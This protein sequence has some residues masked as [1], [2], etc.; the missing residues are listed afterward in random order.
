MNNVI[1]R[2]VRTFGFWDPFFNEMNVSPRS[3]MVNR[4]SSK[5]SIPAVNIQEMDHQFII[6]VAAP[7]LEKADFNIKLEDETLTIS[8]SKE[9]SNEEKTDQL[10]RKEFSYFN[11][12]RSFNL[13]GKVDK[14]DINAVYENGILT[15]TLPKKEEVKNIKKKIEIQ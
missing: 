12:E 8:V 5:N 7:G 2:P 11:F 6:D 1:K 13:D 3:R 15:L 10:I 9:K 14:S 4:S